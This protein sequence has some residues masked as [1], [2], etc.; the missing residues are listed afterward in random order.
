MRKQIT[1]FL[2]LLFMLPIYLNAS[3][4]ILLK[5]HKST[6]YSTVEDYSLNSESTDYD[7]ALMN[8]QVDPLGFLFFGPQITL[9]FQFA[10]MIAVGPYFRYH[11]AGLIYQ[12]VVTDWFSDVTTTSPASYSFGFQAKF[13]I[14]VGSG[15]HRP[16]VEV[17]YEK[18][19][20]SDSWD[21]G[22]T[23]GKRIYEYKSN[24]IHFNAGYRLLTNSS[25]N[26][27]AA[28]GVGIST[29]TKSIGYY[30]FGDEP[31]DYYTLET[32]ILP[33]IQLL[34]GWQLGK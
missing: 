12:G 9:D 6:N 29:D 11:Y 16:Y 10:N 5:N 31:T 8:L 28:V 32:R 21:P 14:P 17:G 23:W 2:S 22:G 7:L 19:K 27:S 15:Q 1:L 13:L 34:L 24:V 18:S 20:G 26:L 30:E 33:M 25:F 4:G 3:D